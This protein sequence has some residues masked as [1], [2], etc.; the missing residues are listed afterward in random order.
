MISCLRVREIPIFDLKPILQIGEETPIKSLFAPVVGTSLGQGTG[1]EHF[2]TFAPGV[3]T[4]L[5]QGAA[6]A[7]TKKRPI[8]I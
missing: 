4:E 1:D 7:K 5:R 6:T 8:L 2:K 3:T